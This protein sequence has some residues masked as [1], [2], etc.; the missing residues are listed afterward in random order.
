MPPGTRIGDTVRVRTP[1]RFVPALIERRQLDS[2]MISQH[3]ARW[4]SQNMPIMHLPAHDAMLDRRYLTVNLNIPAEYQYTRFDQLFE[5][6]L[7]P[8]VGE[9]L[10]QMS[11]LRV[12]DMFQLH[13]NQGVESSSVTNVDDVSL[14][15]DRA[16]DVIEHMWMSRITIG[17]V[18]LV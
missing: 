15:Y 6:Y 11:Q 16:F 14:R 1:D 10:N 4:L 7:N 8:A 12:V 2:Q 5:R 13:P 3:C 18:V 17:V 9:L